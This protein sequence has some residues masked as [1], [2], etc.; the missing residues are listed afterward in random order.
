MISTN[1][2]STSLHSKSKINF[3][4]LES[5]AMKI[6]SF[7]AAA[8]AMVA[9]TSMTSAVHADPRPLG[10]V[11]TTSPLS[12][13]FSTQEHWFNESFSFST[14]SRGVINIEVMWGLLNG[15]NLYRVTESDI[16]NPFGASFLIASASSEG[17]M[18]SLVSEKVNAGN[19]YFTVSGVTNMSPYG[20]FSGVNSYGGTISVTA[21]PEP[22]TY[23][24]LLA[25]LG[26]V[27]FAARRRNK[28]GNKNTP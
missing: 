26:V 23:A 12:F 4:I 15:V 16:N 21:V 13:G 17:Y 2:L 25:G 28:V 5:F 20:H 1:G 24:M 22:E 6:G 18:I 14:D 7:L 27:G 10:L 8:A 3:H 9:L 11:K 19:Y